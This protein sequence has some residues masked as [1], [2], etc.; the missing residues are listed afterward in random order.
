MKFSGFRQRFRDFNQDLQISRKISDPTR[1]FVR[2]QDFVGDFSRDFSKWRTPRPRPYQ[3]YVQSIYGTRHARVGKRVRCPCV[4]NCT[5][6]FLLVAGTSCHIVCT[7][8]ACPTIN[9]TLATPLPECTDAETPCCSP[10]TACSSQ[11]GGV[12]PQHT[13]GRRNGRLFPPTKNYGL[14]RGI[15][16]SNESIR[17]PGSQSRQ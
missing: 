1:D 13:I 2:F 9:I 7:Y 17:H 5:C 3:T 15:N 11:F 12:Q 4:Y 14:E 10:V 6:V 8:L 16:L